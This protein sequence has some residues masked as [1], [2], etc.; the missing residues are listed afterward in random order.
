MFIKYNYYNNKFIDLLGLKKNIKY[1]NL[2]IIN[3][4]IN[5]IYNTNILNALQ[6]KYKLKNNSLHNELIYLL[7]S[8]INQDLS[9]NIIN[10]DLSGN[11]NIQN[12]LDLFINLKYHLFNYG[13]I[14]QTIKMIVN[15]FEDN[16]KN[17]IYNYKNKGRIIKYICI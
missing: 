7:K 3:R 14:K 13:T 4:V 5:K 11:I 16:T 8:I 17:L 2:F 12:L 1:H 10:Q 15:L 9:G 6:L